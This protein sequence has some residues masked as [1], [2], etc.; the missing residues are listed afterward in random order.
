MRHHPAPASLPRNAS[1]KLELAAQ[2]IRLSG[3]SATITSGVGRDKAFS[4]VITLPAAEQV[5]VL[6]IDDN[7][8]TLNLYHRYLSGS[9]YRFVGVSDP[10]QVLSEAERLAPEIIVLDVML[11]GIDGWQLLG[12]LREH[13]R[14]RDVPIVVCTIMP[15][16]QLALALGADAFI[17]KP[18][19]QTAFLSALDEQ[20]TAQVREAR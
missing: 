2:L 5:K 10:N 9:R 12:A 11:P 18:V 7:V 17:T 19:A 13:P 1:Q 4:A 14:T 16:E 6:V 15:Q 8:D 20:V 3:G